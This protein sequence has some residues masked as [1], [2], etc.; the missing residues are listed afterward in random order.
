MSN[1]TGTVLSFG[2]IEKIV[3]CFFFDHIT[4][5]SGHYINIYNIYINN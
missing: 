5:V 4:V 2:D 3:F 1:M